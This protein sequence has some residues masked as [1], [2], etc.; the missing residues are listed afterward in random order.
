MI[1]ADVTNSGYK[2]HVPETNDNDSRSCSFHFGLREQ[3]RIPGAD[4]DQTERSG[5]LAARAA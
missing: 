4:N 3:R 1:T 5:A 2:D